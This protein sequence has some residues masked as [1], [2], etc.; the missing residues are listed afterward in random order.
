MEKFDQKINN[1]FFTEILP[2][3]V[4]FLFSNKPISEYIKKVDGKLSDF[5]ENFCNQESIPIE[6]FIRKNNTETRKLSIINPIGQ[7]Y[8]LLYYIRYDYLIINFLKKSRYSAR[9]P[10]KLNK[11]TLNLSNIKEKI[12]QKI[13]EEYNHLREETLSSDELSYFYSTYFSYTFIKRITDLY[14]SPRFNHAKQKYKYFKKL[15]INNFFNSIYTHSL[16]WAIFG[17]K[18]FSKKN[19]GTN[20]I[21]L[22]GNATDKISQIINKNETNGIVVGPEFS[23]IIAELLLSQIDS[24]VYQKLEESDYYLNKDYLIFRY[25]DDYFIFANSEMALVTIEEILFKEFEK[26]RLIVNLGKSQSQRAPFLIGHNGVTSLKEVIGNFEI[27]KF[28]YFSN[29]MREQLNGDFNLMVGTNKQWTNYLNSVE[30]IIF[31]NFENKSSIVLYLL[32]SIKL[33]THITDGSV[34]VIIGIIEKIVY[35]YSLHIN[36]NTTEALLYTLLEIKQ[37]LVK[38]SENYFNICD[39]MFNFLF[40]V[41]KNHP[42]SIGENYNILIFMKFL[43]KRINSQFLCKLVNDFDDYFVLC[44]IAFYIKE[45]NFVHKNYKVVLKKIDSKVRNILNNHTTYLNNKLFDSNFY[46]IAN[47]FSNYLPLRNRDKV[48]NILINEINKFKTPNENYLKQFYHS[49]SDRS[50]FDWDADEEKIKRTQ[51][52][53]RIAEKEQRKQIY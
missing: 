42:D 4:P 28:R 36:Y 21:N 37:K 10:A 51:I 48:K 31:E 23:R 13:E 2:Y 25:V 29:N 30:K 8:V 47:D 20:K 12:A 49:L 45:N 17:N 18:E 5:N 41:L 9:K 16:S 27:A 24:Q 19:R 52:A 26:Y 34:R 43:P 6:F 40:G 38:N 22:F 1:F 33:P 32:K 50:F 3:E 44:C 35:I 15:D 39:K 53:K 7:I 14:S 11:T 46:F